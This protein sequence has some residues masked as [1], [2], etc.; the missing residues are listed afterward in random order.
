MLATQIFVISALA[1]FD[2]D[3]DQFSVFQTLMFILSAT[4][5]LLGV[6]MTEREQVERLLRDHRAELARVGAQAAAAATASTVAHEI[7]Q[8]LSAMSVY[9]HSACLILDDGQMTPSVAEARAALAEAE[10]QGQRTRAIIQRVRDFIAGG[11]LA[12]ES[13]DL[14][15]LVQKV[16]KL[17]E[18]EAQDRGVALRVEAATPIPSVRADRIAIEQALN[19]LIKNTIDSASERKNSLGGVVIRLSQSGDRV[20]FD[21]DDNGAGVA[22]E[23]AENLFETFETTKPNGMGLGLPLALQ[24]V[25]RHSGSLTWRALKPQGARFSIELPIQGPG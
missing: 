2:V 23:V 14:F 22:P 3:D 11:K 5:L 17:N 15:H 8:P 1:Y 9:L 24:I 12:L 4:G 19:N 25:R 21:I 6:A 20:V 16:S 7:S 18:E 13:L 10:A